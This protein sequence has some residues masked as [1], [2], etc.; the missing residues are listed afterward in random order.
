V[1]VV[2]AV[3][4]WSSHRPQE[5]PS[6][7]PG[8][9]VPAGAVVFMAWNVE[10]LFDDRDDKR[11][12]ID[13][14]YDNWFATDPAAR[15]LKYTH[16]A[17]IILKVNNGNG[18]DILA[19]VEV[20]SLRA[21]T[22][23]KD[24]LNAKLPAAAKRYEFVAMKELSPS[25]GRYIAPCV[26]SKLP[27]DEANTHLVGRND[28]RI[29]ETHVVA[30][31]HDLQLVVGHWTSKL[32]QAD[33]SDGR[34]GREKYAAA[35]AAD[36]DAAVKA[37]P[38][39]DFLLCGDFNDTPD[40]HPIAVTLGLTADRSAVIETAD[41]PRLF[42]L[43][44]GKPADRFGTLYHDGPQIYD[45]IGVSAGL[46]DDKGWSCDP[47]SVRV[48]TDGMIRDRARTRNPWRFGGPNESP[49]G[50]GYADHF[51]VVVNLKLAP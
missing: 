47:D 39:V 46:L 9:P 42:G 32:R 16:L 36:Y 31:A 44:S 5:T 43:L 41:P 50:R 12:R 2:A 45:H 1:L 23:L 25:A 38:A 20:E 17:D 26:I 51:P 28:L 4:W 3:W 18:P 29:L 21:A 8:Q 6:T 7:A 35:I 10:N 27:L 13:D 34:S 37:N 30:N 48:P 19:C 40:S 33:G 11:N 22:L 15:E 24:T 14:P 49:Q